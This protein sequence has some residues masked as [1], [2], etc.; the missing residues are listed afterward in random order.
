MNVPVMRVIKVRLKIR[1]PKKIPKGRQ[2]KTMSWDAFFNDEDAV[3]SIKKASNRLRPGG[4]LCM[5]P[6]YVDAIEGRLKFCSTSSVI[7]LCNRKG[8]DS[9][10][11][12]AL[13]Q[14]HEIP[15]LFLFIDFS[16]FLQKYEPRGTYRASHNISNTLC[17]ALCV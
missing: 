13:W 17:F 2:K 10:S 1:I 6:K 7:G 4:T 15:I 12:R 8:N 5:M 14:K 3:K 16:S 11:C 9:T